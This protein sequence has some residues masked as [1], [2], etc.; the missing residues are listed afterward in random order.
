MQ[1]ESDAAKAHVLRTF[2]WREGHAL[3]TPIFHDPDAL[4]SLGPALAG[5]FRDHGVTAVVSP[6]ARGF[7]LG[8]LSA[9]VL[10]VGFVPARKP[11]SRHA[12]ESVHVTSEPDW[13][14]RRITFRLAKVFGPG[15]RVLI[16]DDWIETGSQATAV[17]LAIE[18]MGAAVVGTSVIVDQ[19]PDSIA[20]AL[21][22]VGI[23]KHD[24]L[25]EP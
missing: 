24:E 4:Q 8:A 3:F 20:S 21:H 18:Q 17:A 11:G 12:G 16:V 1:P 10:G 5:P 13:R 7:I 15:D 19:A 9:A 25:P 6:E 14:G 2:A 23:L 22:V